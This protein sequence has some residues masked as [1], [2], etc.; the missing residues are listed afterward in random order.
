MADLAK[1]TCSAIVSFLIAV[2]RNLALT[3]LNDS[4][5]LFGWIMSEMAVGSG[6]TAP[7]PVLTICI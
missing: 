2:I 7:Q 5:T 4:L 3:P 1:K 6:A